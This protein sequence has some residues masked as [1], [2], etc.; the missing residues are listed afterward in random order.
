MSRNS[1]ICESA[2]QYRFCLKTFNSLIARA[3]RTISRQGQP[4]IVLRPRSC[5]ILRQVDDGFD[6]LNIED[7]S[8]IKTENDKVRGRAKVKVSQFVFRPN[9]IEILHA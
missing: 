9:T 5:W 6:M 3:V 8:K 4:Y 2:V 7:Y 1:R